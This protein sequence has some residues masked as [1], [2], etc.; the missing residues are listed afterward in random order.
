MTEQQTMQANVEQK[1]DA[2]VE[3]VN[4]AAKAVVSLGRQVMALWL[5]VARTAIQA[6]AKTLSTTSEMVSTVAKSMGELSQRVDESAK[7]V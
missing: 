6:A 1:V 4:D 7:K 3:P 2:A 5:G